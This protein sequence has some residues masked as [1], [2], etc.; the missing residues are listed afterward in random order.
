MTTTRDSIADIWGDRTPYGPDSAWPVRV[1]QRTVEEPQQWVQS[2]CVLCSNGCGCD[3]G[4]KDGRIVGVRGRAEDVVNRGRLGPK[5]LHGWEAN[6]SADRL[7][8]PLIRQ[9]GRLQPATWDDAMALIVQKAREAKE[10]YS[11]GALGFYTSGQLFL[12]EYYTLGVI[13][14]AGLGTPHMDGNTRLCTATAAAALKETFGSDGQPGT[15]FDID[16]TDCILMTGHNMSATDTVLWT[17]VLDRRRGP[18]P[19]K[20]IVIDPR[21]TM[22]AREAD[23]HLAPRLG[24]NVAVLNGLLHL[25]IARGYADTEFLERHTIGFARLKQVVAEY[26]PEAV[27]RISGVPA[28]DLMRAAEMIGSSGKLLSTCLQ[29]VYQSNQATAAAVQVNNINLVLGRIGR[30]GCGILQ[31]NG[32]PTSQ[33]T[34]E[35]G[36][37]GDLPAFRNWDNIEHIQE[38]ARLWNVD[39]AI[40]PHWTPPTHSLQIFRY[41]ETGSIRFLWIQATNPAV[42]LPNLDRVRKILR[43]PELFV[44]VQDAFM[45]ETAELAD[46]VLPTALWGEKTGCFTNV[47]RTVHISHKAVEPPGQARSDLD[48]FLDF[49]RRMDLRDKDGQPLIPWTTP[50]QAFEAWKACT[51]GRPCDYTGLSYAKL[52]RGSGICWPCNE[53]HPEGNHYPYQSL[54]FPTDPDVCESYG[55]DLTTGG[56]VSEQAYRAMNPAGRAIL[57]AAHYKPPVE[58]AD[59]AYPFFLTTGRLVYHFHT[60]TKTGRAAALAQAAPDDFL[61]ISLEDAQRLGIQD[62]DWV[63]ITSRRGRV[64]ARA[65]IGDIPPGEVF[66]PFHY[67]YWDSPG[68]ARAANEITLYEWDPVSKQPHYKYAA[69]KVERIDAPSVAQPQEVSLNPLGEPA[70]SGLA[71]ATAEIKEALARGVAEVKPKRAHVADYIGLLQESERRLVKGFEQARATHPD[72]PDIGPL[73]ALFASWS[74]ESAQALDPFVARY[75]ERREGEPERLDQALLV[76]RSQGGFDMLRDLHD[77]WLM[78]NESLISLDALEQAARSL[79]DKAFEEAI[80]SIREKNS[81]QATWLRTRIRQ[82][83]PQTLVVPS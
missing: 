38:L 78:V 6:N 15:Y 34:R 56:M 18:Q 76:Q 57:K 22:T 26:P 21:A 5:G 33:N 79:H 30:P 24:T 54:V 67:G 68:H 16:A 4:V 43:Q 77:L 1:D 2:A 48:I 20:L 52:S 51:R 49:A 75:G 65:R 29:G 64:E 58:T 10:K 69:V 60:R 71:E 83:A 36:A 19:P 59:D 13:G 82:A 7:L 74:Q 23:L 80:T 28:A 66:M 42:S 45:T 14:K 37:D 55:H 47:D 11:A 41:C 44:V 8:T 70:R 17:R 50:E 3:I 72:E 35:A 73:C 40:I 62:D 81:R 53:A 61:Q 12:E 25:L 63:R 46:V 27:A 32:Q 9:G 31:M 39:P